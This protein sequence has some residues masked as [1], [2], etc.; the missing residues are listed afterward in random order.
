[1]SIKAVCFDC[2][3]VLVD[4]ISSWRII[5]DHFGTNSGEM[6]DRFLR[7]E[8]TDEEFMADDIR[9]WKSVQSQIHRDEL[10][11]CFQGIKL[12]PGARELVQALQSRGVLVAI[13]S[14]GVDLLIGSI[15]QMLNVDD[16]VSNGFRY[17]DDGFL[18]DEGEVRV[19]AHHK[20]DMISKMAR[21][22]NLDPSEIVSVGDNHTD[23]SMMIPGSSFIGFNGEKQIAIDGF[24]AAGVPHIQEKDCRLLWPHFFE[25]ESFP[26]VGGE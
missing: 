13:V 2:D 11:R 3:G 26:A 7:G 5:H 4:T 8:V 10:M 14:A 15:A 25:G 19:P 12:M 1:M 20:D 24:A 22:H 17:D 21:I 6:L 16:W 18:L 9:L 23:L